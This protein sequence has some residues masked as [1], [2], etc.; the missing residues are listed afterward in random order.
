LNNQLPEAEKAAFEVI[1]QFGSYDYW[2]TSSYILIG[3]VYLKQNDLFNAEATFKSVSE[4]AT[5]NELKKIAGE[6]L[7]GVIALKE[8]ITKVQ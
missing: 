2:V 6:K 5:I 1:K 4:N 7:L 3:D 8:K